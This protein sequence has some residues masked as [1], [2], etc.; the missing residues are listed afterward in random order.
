MSRM[1]LAWLA[2]AKVIM[3]LCVGSVLAGCIGLSPPP[4]IHA[5]EYADQIKANH[6]YHR[7][8]D[9][10]NGG[11]GTCGCN[12][13]NWYI[14]PAGA[15]PVAVFTGP[16]LSLASAPD[17]FNDKFWVWLAEGNGNTHKTG[18]CGISVERLRREAGLYMYPDLW[19]LSKH[20]VDGWNHGDLDVLQLHIGC[21]LD[22]NPPPR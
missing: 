10:Y 13:L 15:D 12:L 5:Q 22:L 1:Y 2:I 21:N 9:H 6:G 4:N 11:D 16:D 18:N 19:H 14:G 17:R 20:E 7:I 8:D 3:L